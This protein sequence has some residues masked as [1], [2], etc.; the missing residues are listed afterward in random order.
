MID[1]NQPTR[2]A[3]SAMTGQGL[4]SL[5]DRIDAMLSIGELRL[6]YDLD[7][8]DGAAIAW[9]HQHGRVFEQKMQDTDM[10]V[11]VVLAA[12]DASRFDNRFVPRRRAI[13]LP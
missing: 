4:A 1:R 8:A 7:P 13:A 3:L 5:V 10:S 9:L 6:R 12:V 2:I 11:Y